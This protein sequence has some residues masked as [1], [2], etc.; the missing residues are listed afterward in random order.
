MVKKDRR[1]VIKSKVEIGAYGSGKR[2]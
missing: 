1:K 2:L